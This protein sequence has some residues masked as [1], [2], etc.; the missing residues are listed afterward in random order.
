MMIVISFSECECAELRYTADPRPPV[1]HTHLR[2]FSQ[3]SDI[4]L[5]SV[6]VA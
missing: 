5:R 6:G 4:S 2:G 3:S 1:T